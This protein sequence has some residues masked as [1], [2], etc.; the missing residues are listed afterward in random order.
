MIHDT[1]ANERAFIGCLLRSPH[2]FWQINDIVTADQFQIGHYRDIFTAVRDLSERGKQVTIT[3]LQTTLPEE[4]DE[5]GPAIAVLM[6][7]KE[8]AND[9]GSAS[10]YAPFLAERSALKR[11][12]ALSDWIRKEARRG[13]KAAEEI[14]A[15]AATRLQAIMATATPL[16]PVK[17]SEIT[18]RVVSFSERARGED[19]LPGYTTGLSGLDEMTGLL[20]GGDFIG[21]LGAL[22][23]GKSA[24]LAQIGKHISKSVPVLNCNNEMSEEQNG[25]RFIA[26]E[27]GMSVREIREGAYDFTGRDMVDEAQ[28]K[29]ELLNYHLY[30]DPRMTVRGIRVRALQMKQTIG[31]GAITIDGMKRLRTDTK[32]RDRWDRLEEITGELKAMAIELN[33]PILLAVQRTRTAR[34]R[35][36][37]IP[38]LDDAD[39]PTLETDADLVLGV[40]REESFLM[41]NKPNAKAGGEAWDEWEGKIRRAKGIG[42]IIALKVR[43]GKPFEQKEFRWNG[44]ATRFEEL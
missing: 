7:L 32:H 23:D 38:Q 34:R 2:E 43:S 16:R 17:L 14:S 5:V 41:M 19:V 12:D 42:K 8:S 39:A 30:T 21:I 33:V 24:L 36:D 11:L 27:S 9:A 44:P 25:T 6:A 22:G 15:D 18:K 40:F 3:A 35:D 13:D 10:D 29:I 20:M 26:G 1:T 4:F 37:P 28:K 31:L